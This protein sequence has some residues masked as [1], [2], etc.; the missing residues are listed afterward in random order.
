MD[1]SAVLDNALAWSNADILL[2]AFVPMDSWGFRGV[3][4]HGASFLARTT[5]ERFIGFAFAQLQR[6]I[7]WGIEVPASPHI[8][9][10]V[11]RL[12]KDLENKVIPTLERLSVTNMNGYPASLTPR[13]LEHTAS[14]TAA[15]EATMV[16][17]RRARMHPHQILAA[18]MDPERH[19]GH[20]AL[21]LGHA[22]ERVLH[23]ISHW[24]PTSTLYHLYGRLMNTALHR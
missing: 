11:D 5:P 20:H 14:H 12:V 17:A 10:L 2:P 15:V 7:D 9:E 24:H 23:R 4:Y 22:H 19:R 6:L 8:A 1:R 18:V 21:L 13:S 3:L 16:L